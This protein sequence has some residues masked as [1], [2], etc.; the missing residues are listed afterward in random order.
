MYFL[1]LGEATFIV[2]DRSQLL[3]CLD[4]MHTGMTCVTQA[5]RAQYHDHS[6]AHTTRQVGVVIVI[7]RR[8][9]YRLT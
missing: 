9:R 1:L 3:E 7:V 4:V 2:H 6:D 8:L 5:R